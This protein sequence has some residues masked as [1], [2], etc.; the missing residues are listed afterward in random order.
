M[1]LPKEIIRSLIR[2]AGWDLHRLSPGS[3]SAFQL[4]TALRRFEV[5]LVLDVGGNVGQF[6]KSLRSIGYDGEL[7]SFEPTSIAH[8]ALTE[9]ASHDRKWHVH[10]RAAIGE[11]DGETEI[12]VAGN[13]VSS[14]VLPM[15]DSHVSAAAASQ[16][17]TTEKVPMVRLDSVAP[18]YLENARRPFLKIDAQGYEWQVLDGAREV[19]PRLQGVLCELSLVPLYEGGRLWL[20]VVRRPEA[21]GFALWSIQKGFTDPRDGRMLQMDG[22]FFRV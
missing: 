8:H 21:E 15:M 11:Y 10:T 1:S 4:L 2:S 18:M 16:Y 3:N 19:L 6:G 14:S 13:S 5:D 7:V 17:V 22:A 20:D 9:A 12:H